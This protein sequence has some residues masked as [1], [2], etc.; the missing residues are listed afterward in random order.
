MINLSYSYL[1]FTLCESAFRVAVVVTCCGKALSDGRVRLSLLS[2]KISNVMSNMVTLRNLKR[3]AGI[4]ESCRSTYA[5]GLV[6]LMCEFMSTG[7]HI[8]KIT[9]T[10]LLLRDLRRKD[11]NSTDFKP[12]LFKTARFNLYAY[13]GY[14]RTEYS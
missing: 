12:R 5:N 9:S 7:S 11:L 3:L 13:I 14:R 4:D 2:P 1:V 8:V 6:V 10:V